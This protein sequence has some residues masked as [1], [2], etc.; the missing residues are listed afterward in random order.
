MMVDYV[1]V[2]VFDLSDSRESFFMR[3]ELSRDRGIGKCEE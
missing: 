3:K 1:G 2:I